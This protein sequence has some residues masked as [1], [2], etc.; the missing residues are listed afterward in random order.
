MTTRRKILLGSAAVAAAGVAGL[1]W[2]VALR[3]REPAGLPPIDDQGRALWSNWSGIAHSYPARR[4][5]PADEAEL[6][7]LLPDTPLPIRPV[8]AGHSFTAIVPTEGTLLSLDRLSGIVASDPEAMTATVGAGTKLSALGPALAKI[9]QDMINLPDI[10]KQTLGGALATGTHGTGKGVPA[11]HGRVT[12]MRIVAPDGTVIEC[13]RD[14]RPEV[15]DA[16]RVGLGAFGVVSQVTLQNWPLSRVKKVV[17][18]VDTDTLL[19]QWPALAERHRNAEF[20]A[21]PFTG[22]SALVTHDVTVEPVLPR[23]PDVDTDALMELKTLRDLFEFTPALRRR[24]AAH[25]LDG[26]PPEIAVD[27]GWK[28]LANARP[29]RFKEMEYHLP[30]DEQ[31][32]ALREVIARIERDAKDVFFPIEA[33]IVAPDDAWLSPFNGRESGSIA[34]HA[35]YK[36]AN[37][38]M[39]D[40][41]EPV[42]R[43][44]G[45]R[46]HWG[47]LHSLAAPELKALYP[48]FT[49][50]MAVRKSL[51]PQGRLL[52]PFLT[53]LF[54]NG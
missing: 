7:A 53:R 42:L 8:G 3:D 24:F 5:A 46:P 15:F 4:A 54:V 45:G 27:E 35:Y 16:A 38:W 18:V 23:G 43:E 49:E 52:N 32:A 40:L 50:A 37:D 17:R 48:M 39:F 41:I 12:A 30:I 25:F 28:L 1:G 19:D 34:V 14:Q 31:V 26:T 36:E 13:N 2:R 51:D 22:K 44:A 20:L 9:G 47:K 10:D 11:L 29:V 33:R 6:A 21:L